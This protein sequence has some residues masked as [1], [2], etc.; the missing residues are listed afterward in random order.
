METRCWSSAGPSNCGREVT[1]GDSPRPP[2]TGRGG[3]IGD[4]RLPRPVLPTTTQCN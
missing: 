4:E 3:N 1:E 2:C